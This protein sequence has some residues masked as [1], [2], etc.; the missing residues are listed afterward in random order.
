[1]LKTVSTT[2]FWQT[3]THPTNIRALSGP[4]NHQKRSR[5]RGG[6][7]TPLRHGTTG[8][9]SS[10]A[11]TK[12][13]VMRPSVDATGRTS[14]VRRPAN[15]P[16]LAI[17]ASLVAAAPAHWLQIDASARVKSAYV[18]GSSGSAMQTFAVPAEQLKYLTRLIATTKLCS[19]PI[20][21]TYLY[22]EVFPA[23]L[24]LGILRYMAL[25]CIVEKP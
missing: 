8:I 11:T 21:L 9:R 25:V 4:E 13:A 24:C 23:R 1:M 19:R 16:C 12:G 15:A 22:K 14:P 2:G 20:V 10:L 5:R 6:R 17:G 18:S 3:Q 7:T